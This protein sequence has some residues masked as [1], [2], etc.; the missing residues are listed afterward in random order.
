LNV[1]VL[2]MLAYP[3]RFNVIPPMLSPQENVRFELALR[4][5]EDGRP[6]W[7][8]RIPPGLPVDALP[9]LTPRD[10]ALQGYAVVPKDFPFAIGLTALLVRVDPRLALGVS[11]LS[12]TALLAAVATLAR[13]LGGPWSGVAASA[14]LATTGSFMAGTSGPLNIGAAV[15]AAVVTGVLLLVPRP[16]RPPSNS[17]ASSSGRAWY[18][19]VLAGISWGVAANLHHDV[20]LLAAG[21][22]VPFALPSQGGLLR[23]L[24]VGGGF[25]IALLPGLGYYAWLNGSPFDTGYALAART[26]RVPGGHFFA[27]LSLDP[28]MLIQHLQRYVTHTEVCVLLAG[29][30]LASRHAGSSPARRLAGG[31]MLG[32][33][34]YLVFLGSRPLYGVDRFTLGASFLRY[35]L[36]VVALLVCLCTARPGTEPP[37]SHWFRATALGVSAV[38]GI[39]LLAQSPGG[40]VDQRRQVLE[41]TQLRADILRVT[42]PEAIVV[43]ARGDKVLWPHRIT[44]TAA[45]LVRDPTEG[46]RNGPTTFDVV[47]TPHRLAQVVADL[48]HAGD[49]VYVLSDSLPPGVKRLDVELE[50]AGARREPTA[51]RSLFL[52]VSTH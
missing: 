22:L 7:A 16:G 21:L 30:F 42:E 9:A 49:R 19:D 52:I 46:I 35:M 41:S 26:L 24:R 38:V 27:I 1:A 31:L 48:A 14:V 33:V 12:G 4:W 20:V 32:A 6:S 2:H 34:P 28:S 23:V 17:V 51:V 11:L 50:L 43:T 44:L 36:P 45:Y 13:R 8:L 15:A 39:V 10:A 37:L 25:L 47:P 18:R 5:V 40:V 29:A 3:G